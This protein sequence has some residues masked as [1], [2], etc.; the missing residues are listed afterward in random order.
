MSSHV[1]G[2]YLS[3]DVSVSSGGASYPYLGGL[4]EAVVV[5]VVVAAAIAAVHQ[6]PALPLVN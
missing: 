1:C 4:V 6:A 2:C 5:V 3:T